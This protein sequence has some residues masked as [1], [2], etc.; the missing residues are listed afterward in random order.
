MCY[1]HNPR[2]ISSRVTNMVSRG[3]VSAFGE[4]SQYVK[5]GL[6]FTGSI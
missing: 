4:L 2:A 3:A 1:C 5:T 6:R